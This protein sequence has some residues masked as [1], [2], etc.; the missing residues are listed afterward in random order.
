MNDNKCIV[1]NEVIPEGRMVCPTCENGESRLERKRDLLYDYCNN[2]SCDKCVLRNNSK[3]GCLRISVATEK[4]LNKALKL[5][6]K[7]AT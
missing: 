5:I 6:K 7:E 3:R 1:C 2:I 4:E